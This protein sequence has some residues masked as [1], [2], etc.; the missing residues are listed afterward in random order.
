MGLHR[1]GVGFL[2]DVESFDLAGR[3]TTLRITLAAFVE[4]A[5]SSSESA[6]TLYMAYSTVCHHARSALV[7]VDKMVPNKMGG[8][9]ARSA[10][11]AVCERGIGQP[12]LLP[13]F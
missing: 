3:L 9:D 6:I 5:A 4:P 12:I 10:R 11:E 8:S 1:T 2:L 7:D 13:S